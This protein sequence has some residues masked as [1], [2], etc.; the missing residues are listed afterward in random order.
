V[1]ELG[2]MK[3]GYLYILLST[4]LFSSMETALKFVSG[5]FNPV[6]L[7]FMRFFIGAIVLSPL[8]FRKMRNQHMKLG[9]RDIL[10]FMLTGFICVVVSMVL[11]Q[12]AILN[13][14]ASIVAILFSC[15]PVFVIPLAYFML[16]EK[17]Y[18]H[19]LVSMLVSI[20]GMIWIMNP[21]KL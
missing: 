15:N 2:K 16:G 12:L 13:T 5:Q 6:Q 20:F 9:K 18:K 1:E 11:Y 7:T 10:F 14:P 19:T 17:I 8:A 3:K 21:F 4:I